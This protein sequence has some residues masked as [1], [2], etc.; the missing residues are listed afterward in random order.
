MAKT[1]RKTPVQRVGTVFMT[2]MILLGVLPH[3]CTSGGRNSVATL[4]DRVRAGRFADRVVAGRWRATGADDSEGR[5]LL[6]GEVCPAEPT[7]RDGDLELARTL[8]S[9]RSLHTAALASTATLAAK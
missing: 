3:V 8:L 6:R 9:D 2:R 4:V 5:K 7:E 1:F